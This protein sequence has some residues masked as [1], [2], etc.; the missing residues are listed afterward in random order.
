MM[1]L[2]ALLYYM[3]ESGGVIVGLMWKR[4]NDLNE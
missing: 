4:R 1:L 2:D 3:G